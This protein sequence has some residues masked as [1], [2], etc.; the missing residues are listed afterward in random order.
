VDLADDQTIPDSRVGAVAA[1]LAR[2]AGRGPPVGIAPIAGGGNNRVFAV[3]MADGELLVV[4]TYFTSR[5]DRRDRLGAEWSFLTFAWQRGIRC[6]PQPFAI[7]VETSSALYGFIAGRRPTAGEIEARQVQAAA[8]FVLQLN[9]APA[10]RASLPVAS[11]ACFTLAQHLSTVDRRIERLALLDPDAPCRDEAERFIASELRPAWMRVR[12][13]IGQ[14]V[15]ALGLALDE[16][17]DPR[18]VCISPSD[19]GFHNA[20]VDDLGG[21]S[22]LDFEY[23]G[24]DDPAKLVCDFFCQPELPVPLVHYRHFTAAVIEGLGLGAHHQAQCQ[25][26]LDAYRVKW[27]AIILNDFLPAGAARR[28]FAAAGFRAERCAAQL[29]KARDRL[30]QLSAA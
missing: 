19:L 18:K 11:E 29:G 27:I 2:A 6:I 12:G 4:K 7:D 13:R 9:P 8:D 3:T 21:I 15:R 26:L 1:R 10:E 25:I 20:L 16:V 23:A 24:R 14:E 22:F 28:A 5:H 30:K 17:L